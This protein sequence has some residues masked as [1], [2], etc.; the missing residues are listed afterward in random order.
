MNLP[1]H[2]GLLGSLEAGLIALLIGLGAYWVSQFLC[3]RAGLSL[4]HAIGWACLAAVAIGAGWDIWNLFYTSIVRLESP[5][6]ARLALQ[7]IH[8]PDQLGGRVVLEVVGALAGVALGWRLF[9]AEPADED[10]ADS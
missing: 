6:Y 1:L 3:R 9:S 5:L 8:D 4:G 10:V 2:F 7:S